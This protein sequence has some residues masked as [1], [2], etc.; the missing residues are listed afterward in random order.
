[1]RGDDQLSG[2]EL[3][4]QQACHVRRVTHKLRATPGKVAFLGRVVAF[5]FLRGEEWRQRFVL[6]GKGSQLGGVRGSLLYGW[7]FEGRARGEE[8]GGVDTFKE[9]NERGVEGERREV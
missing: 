5:G 2:K 8:R 6:N 3:P 1:M 9:T 4:T 7:G